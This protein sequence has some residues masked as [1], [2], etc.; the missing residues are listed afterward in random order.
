MEAWAKQEHA[1]PLLVAGARRTGKTR[2]AEHAGVKF[3]QNKYVRIDFQT[4]LRGTSEIF[5]WPTND[6]DG[7][8]QRIGEYAGQII[9]PTSTLII[10]DEIQLCESA[11]N[12]LR[13]FADAC[14]KGRTFHIL[15]TGSLLH[16]IA[17]ER[18]LPFPSGVE[19]IKLHAM[20][21]EE[22][23]WAQ[24]ENN[25]AK[26]IREHVLLGTPYVAHEKALDLYYKYLVVGGM[27]KAVLTY[28]T[29]RDFSCVAEVQEEI[30]NTY[31]FDMTDER[32]N[33][34]AVSAKR[35]WDS[36]PR[37]LLRASTKKFKYVDVQKGGRRARLLDPLYWLDAAGIVD[38][39]DLTRCDSAPL[40]PFSDEEG[41]F[42][43]V[44]VADTGIMFY[45][46]GISPETF[47]AQ[48][49]RGELASDFRGA[50]AENYIAQMLAANELKTFYWMPQDT[51]GA[52][53]IDFVYQ[54]RAARIIP[55]EVK[56]GRNV[57]SATFSHFLHEGKSPIGV[58][59]STSN[60]AKTER[61]GHTLLSL[62]LY[63]AFCIDEG[64]SDAF[65]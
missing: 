15:A 3:F 43:K 52:G 28:V 1:L 51:V 16:V 22:F 39:H 50:L 54:D 36:I 33:R 2:C 7:L 17:K 57:S 64:F 9:D 53:E 55:I 35:I 13:F 4:D 18:S 5:N 23:L 19:Q 20:D 27:P 32:Y 38:I 14:E 8:I 11:L 44:Y 12:S 31:T 41:S 59:F 58:R 24:N 48:G 65:S 6:V 26:A 49:T 21:F 25:V 60:F 29:T 56:S 63:A 37:Q 46:F 40:V 42:F 47:L 10:L 61:E 30:N 62:P 34:N 45:K